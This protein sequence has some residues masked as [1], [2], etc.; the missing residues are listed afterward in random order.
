MNVVDIDALVDSLKMSSAIDLIGK[1]PPE[2]AKE[3]IIRFISHFPTLQSQ[4]YK[5]FLQPE[6]EDEPYQT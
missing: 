5:V 4:G 1:I 3:K 6:D 2:Q